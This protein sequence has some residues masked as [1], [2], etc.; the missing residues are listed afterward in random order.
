MGSRR[1]T[2]TM[3]RFAFLECSDYPFYNTHDVLFYARGRL[4][5]AVAAARTTDDAEPDASRARGRPTPGD[6]E[7]TGEPQVERCRDRRPHDI[8]APDE[9]PWL[10][11]QR[12]R[13]PGPEPLEGPQQQVR[14]ARLSRDRAGWATSGLVRDAWPA[15]RRRWRSSSGRHDGDGLPEHEGRPGPDVRHVADERPVGVRRR[16]VAGRALGGE[17]VARELGDDTEAGRIGDLRERAWPATAGASGTDDTCCMTAPVAR[18]PTAS[19]PTSFAALGDP[20]DWLDPI[21]RRRRDADR[22]AGPSWSTTS[23]ASA[24]AGWGPSTGCVRTAAW[25]V[26][27]AVAGGVA[28]RDVHAGRAAAGERAG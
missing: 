3:G 12:V 4:A 10:Q 24:T 26:Q 14:A 21:S 17:E 20:H 23:A 22:A 18:T 25:T 6:H 11:L 19:W 15:M 2:R 5:P 8:G 7:A 9:D 27:R 28:R 13:V 1:R 16:P